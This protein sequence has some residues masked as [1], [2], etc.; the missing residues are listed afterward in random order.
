MRNFHK[1]KVALFFLLVGLFICSKAISA[2]DPEL[3]WKRLTQVNSIPDLARPLGKDLVIKALITQGKQKDQ[4][5]RETALAVVQAV[6]KA[7]PLLIQRDILRGD[8][9][10]RRDL[11][12]A[13]VYSNISK[14]E[15]ASIIEDLTRTDGGDP[16]KRK[17]L[18]LVMAQPSILPIILDYVINTPND[19][20]YLLKGL[21]ESIEKNDQINYSILKLQKGDFPEETIKEA[22]LKPGDARWGMMERLEGRR[23]GSIGR[24]FL[25]RGKRNLEPLFYDVFWRECERWVAINPILLKEFY[26]RVTTAQPIYDRLQYDLSQMIQKNGGK[27]VL[28]YVNAG[29]IPQSRFEKLSQNLLGQNFKLNGKTQNLGT[30]VQENLAKKMVENPIYTNYLLWH[31]TRPST[32]IGD[33]TIRAIREELGR[34]ADLAREMA[35]F[36][37]RP[38]IGVMEKMKT[39][40][41]YSD[42]WKARREAGKL[43][44]G[45]WLEYGKNLGAALATK[46]EFLE[47]LWLDQPEAE[48][49]VWVKLISVAV[50]NSDEATEAWI[51]GMMQVDLSVQEAFSK[52]L[53][54]SGAEQSLESALENL[55]RVKAQVNAHQLISPLVGEWK[56]RW[57]DWIQKDPEAIEIVARR[58]GVETWK[59]SWRLQSMLID[60]WN[61][62]IGAF[63]EWRSN[64]SFLPE[65]GGGVIRYGVGALLSDE[66]FARL[67]LKNCEAG[68]KFLL[69]II[70]PVWKRMFNESKDEF[71][72]AIKNG[73][74][75]GTLATGGL[76]NLGTLSI[77]DLISKNGEAIEKELSLYREMEQVKP[78]ACRETLESWMSTDFGR[79]RPILKRL[80]ENR[81]FWKAWKDSVFSAIIFG[82]KAKDVVR[83]VKNSP[84]FWGIWGNSLREEF[85]KNPEQ[86]DS[87]LKALSMLSEVDATRTDKL[88]R[89]QNLLMQADVANQV[90]FEQMIENPTGNYD[91]YAKEKLQWCAPRP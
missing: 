65:N 31:L 87:C 35:A 5:R 6:I 60:Q 37:D 7:N 85:E 75:E 20:P 88:K 72:K 11:E 63:Q 90:F 26:T 14:T 49:L 84:T 12:R 71:P 56:S 19:Y 81:V 47:E 32:V 67:L 69:D 58:I 51:I 42:A 59:C 10:L 50:V 54:K 77:R 13:L 33:A 29:V 74:L 25:E 4:I 8:Y 78:G 43:Q 52:W 80:L 57:Q 27:F 23:N 53:V 83:I 17:I 79:A 82:D 39:I 34:N 9:R 15:A 36:L 48:R 76:F 2:E 89:W 38:R 46:R 66:D 61:E 30:S 44:S 64:A 91:V 62:D 1:E 41:L 21:S 73:F 28:D 40:A 68:N 22:F 3:L 45:D 86:L 16:E 70:D 55:N 24:L 18:K